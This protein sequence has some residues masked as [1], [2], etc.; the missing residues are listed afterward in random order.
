MTGQ[1][2]AA[3]V[4]VMDDDERG[5]SRGG[6]LGRGLLCAAALAVVVGCSTPPE[7]LPEAITCS[8][9]YRP[10]APTAAGAVQGATTVARGGEQTEQWAQMALSVSYTAGEPDGNAVRLQ[11]EGTE[12]QPIS[13]HLYQIGPSAG[14]LH[15]EFAGGH[16]FTGLIYVHHEGAML[17]VWCAA[18]EE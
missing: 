13:E 6:H 11:V 16:G 18:G 1:P 12:G 14:A 15:T 4:G 10:D 17:Q 3:T 2:R 8:H 5:S 7:P 9:Q